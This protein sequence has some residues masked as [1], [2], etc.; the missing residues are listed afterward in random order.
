MQSRKVDELGRIVLPIE[1][2]TELGIEAGDSLDVS[3]EKN[4]SIILKPSE[5]CCVIC[6]GH[7]G[8]VD[9]RNKLICS[10]CRKMIQAQK[11]S[12]KFRKNKLVQR[13]H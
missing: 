1:V 13:T 10:E 11:Q 12:Y 5:R 4:G 7:E 6:H 2:R 3:V 9:V 8:L